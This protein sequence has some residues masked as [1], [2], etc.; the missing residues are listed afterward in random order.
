MFDWSRTSPPLLTLAALL[1]APAAFAAGDPPE[2]RQK[3]LLYRLIQDCGS[4]HGMTLK[5]GLGPA[6]LPETL[7]DKADESLTDIILN[8]IEGTPMPPWAFETSASEAAW[9]VR[10]LKKGAVHDATH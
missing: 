3:V 1:I 10:V 6:L 4:C 7:K 9:L 2:E 5:G 8:G